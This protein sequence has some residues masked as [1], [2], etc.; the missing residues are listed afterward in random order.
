[1]MDQIVQLTQPGSVVHRTGLLTGGQALLQLVSL[2]LP[3]RK[4]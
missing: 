1:M 4:H 3:Y 2:A